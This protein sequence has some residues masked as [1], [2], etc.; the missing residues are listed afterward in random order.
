[1]NHGSMGMI[2]KQ[3][4]SHSNGSCLIPHAQSLRKIKT[5]LTVFCYWEGVNHKY[6]P[7]GQT[8]NKEYF[9]NVLH[10][11]RDAI[12]QKQLQLWATGDWQLH[13]EIAPDH[14]SRFMQSFLVKHQISQVMKPPY[15]PDLVPWNFWLFPKLNSPL[16]GKRFQTIKTQENMMGQ[17]MGLP[18]KILQSV[19]NSGE[20][21]GE[22]CEVPKCL[23][24][25]GLRCHCP[26]YNVSCIFFNKSLYFS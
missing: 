17:P 11:L 20:M 6:A 8:T 26:M 7:P 23:F 16:E 2:Q 14:P 9:L 10:Q 15:S 12:W 13:H 25:R 5:M 4:P 1:M 22:L 3:R 19:L 21:L 24:W 18:T